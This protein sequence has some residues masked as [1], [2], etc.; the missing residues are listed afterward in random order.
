MF[1]STPTISRRSLLKWGLAAAGTG[2]LAACGQQPPAAPSKP[3]E[4][5]AAAKPT[6]AAG[7]AK[8]AQQISQPTPPPA[9][10]AATPAATTAP[11]AA[12]PTE[13]P[14][15]AKPTEAAKPAAAAQGNI[16]RGGSMKLHRQ[17][18]WPTLDPHTAQTNSLDMILTYDYLTRV[19]LNKQSG[20]WEVKPGLAESWEL[21]DPQTVVMKLRKGVKFHDGTDFNADAVKWNLNRMMTHP[22]SAAK[23]ATAAIDAVEVVDPNTIRL[24]LK[25]PSPTLFVNLSPEADNVGGMMSPTWAEKAGDQGI[26]TGSVGTGPFKL[27]S[28]QPGNQV[29][30]KKFDQYWKQG[31]DGKPLPY[32]DEVVCKYQQDW[33]AALVAMRTGDFDLINGVAGR[34]VPTVEGDAKLKIERLPWS[35]TQ[36]M[37]A[38]NARPGARFAGD[39]MKKVRQAVNYAIDREALAKALGA[40]IGDAN[41]QHLVPGQ[42]GFSDKVTQYKYDPDKAKQLLSE[43]GMPNGF[44]V[45]VDIISRPEDQQ[46]AQ[47]YQQMLEK[48]GIKMQIRPSERVAWVQKTLAGD[49]EMGTLLSG[50]RP[51]PDLVL[52]YRFAKDGPGNYMGVFNEELEKLFADGRTTYDAA[53]RQEIYEKAQNIIADESYLCYIWR[54][55]GVIA[56][57]KSLQ[58]YTPPWTQAITMST[59]FWLDK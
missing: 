54:R 34:D 13:A 11:A 43:A 9:A 42:I 50:V 29:V 38:F 8:P 41:Y 46:N 49:F 4:G 55:Q 39:N 23:I 36:Y 3:A 31:A 27:D 7:A 28:Y 26:A 24:K 59:E 56:M 2:L 6:E 1:G 12:K 35:A 58:G 48:V 17:N 16:K 40:G 18:E 33:N 20:A 44:E 14:A 25:S 10:P 5:P 37:I 32:M 15:A 51:D 21:P 45:T 53:K 57:Q 19:D 47:A 22:K 30:Y 52:G